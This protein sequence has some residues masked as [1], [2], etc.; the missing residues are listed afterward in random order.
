MKIMDLL[1]RANGIILKE[2][3]VYIVRYK[4]IIVIIMN[5]H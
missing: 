3:K 2:R 4:R 5:G 1:I